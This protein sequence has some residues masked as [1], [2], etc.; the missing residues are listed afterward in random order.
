MVWWVY[1]K[2]LVV[3]I[4][5]FCKIVFGLIDKYMKLKL[6]ELKPSEDDIGALPLFSIALWL[7]IHSDLG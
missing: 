1:C 7:L 2:L 4:C 3:M 5:V 6:A